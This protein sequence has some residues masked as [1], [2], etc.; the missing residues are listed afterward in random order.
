MRL[1]ELKKLE[2]K[3]SRAW[4]I[5]EYF[6]W[7]WEYTYAGNALKFF[8]RWRSWAIRCRLKP[9]VQVA[10]TLHNHL[11]NMLTYFR[12]PITNAICEGF[13]SKIQAIKSDA[14]GFRGFKNYRTRILFYCGKL[15]LM[16]DLTG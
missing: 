1:E 6:R 5:K 2:L 7:F 3:T 16:P 12:H 10:K 4:A 9:M 13:N 15:D 14:R 11:D 8:Q